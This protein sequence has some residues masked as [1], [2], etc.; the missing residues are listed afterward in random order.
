MAKNRGHVK[1]GSTVVLV[2]T[3]LIVIFLCMLH[4]NSDMLIVFSLH[5]LS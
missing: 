4:N 2:L 1:P 3:M 5:L